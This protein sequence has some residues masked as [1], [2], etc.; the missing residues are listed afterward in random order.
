[1]DLDVVVT[2]KAGRPVP[3]LKREDFTV[4]VGGNVVPI[5]YFARVEEGAIHAPYLATASPDQGGNYLVPI[6]VTLLASALTFVSEGK[7]QRA[8]ADLS[9]GVLD[10][11]GRMSDIA[12][13][14]AAFTI[15]EGADSSSLVY[16]TK[17]KTRKGNQRIVVNLRD[18]ASGKMGTAKADVRVE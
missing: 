6:S 10:D 14:E 11:S 4:R 18:R 12:R 1:M 3:D 16:T 2:D 9:I 5:D 15:P 7:M 17:L 13:Q 8:T